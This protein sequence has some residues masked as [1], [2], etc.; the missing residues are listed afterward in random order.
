MTRLLIRS[1]R[2]VS[3]SDGH[4]ASF[5]SGIAQ[6]PPHARARLA[7]HR[8]GAARLADR[9]L[10]TLWAPKLPLHER[11][12]SRPEAIFVYPS[13]RRSPPQGLRPQ[14]RLS[15][16]RAIDRQFPQAARRARRDWRDQRRT[17]ASTRRDWI[18]RHGSGSRRSR[19][20]QGGCHCGRYGRVLSRRGP[21]VR[22][23]GA[24]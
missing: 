23:G 12:G 8:A 3:R 9:D 1:D 13:A 5:I 11:T 18:V 21:A 15:A 6:T 16:S 22:R 19:L 4:P 20:R 2:L 17:L 24:R 14:Q 10:Q 7:A